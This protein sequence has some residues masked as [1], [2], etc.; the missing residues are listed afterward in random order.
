MKKVI[1]I[2]LCLG[3]FAATQPIFAECHKVKIILQHKE[4]E[5][6]LTISATPQEIILPDGSSRCPTSKEIKN[7]FLKM[8]PEYALK[9]YHKIR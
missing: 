1:L 5:I 7:K 9:E 2:L 6:T 4:M 3:I 8:F